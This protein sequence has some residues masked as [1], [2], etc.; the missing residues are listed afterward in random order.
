M[1]KAFLLTAAGCLAFALTALGAGGKKVPVKKTAT[2]SHLRQLIERLG[3]RQYRIRQAA[4]KELLKLD[5]DEAIAALQQ[6][7][8][9]SKDREVIRRLDLILPSLEKV[10][11]LR[12]KLVTL[13]MDKRTI[14]E[15][16]AEIS[17]QTGYSINVDNAFNNTKYTFKFDKVPFW[18]ALDEVCRQGKMSIYPYYYGNY[19]DQLRLYSYGTPPGPYINYSQAF[20]FVAGSFNYQ[21]NISFNGSAYTKQPNNLRSESLSFHFSINTEP[22]VPFLQVM[23]PVVTEAYDEKN[24]PMALKTVTSPKYYQPPYYGKYGGGSRSYF[25]STSVALKRPARDSKTA[26][27]IKG[28]IPVMLLSQQKPEIVIKKLVGMKQKNFKGRRSEID[29][30]QVTEANNW[31]NGK[32]YTIAMTVKEDGGTGN[33]DYYWS[34]TLQ[35]RLELVDAKGNKYVVWS[36]SLY[37]RGGRTATGSITFRPNGTTPYGPPVKLTF[38]RWVPI[39]YKI[40][41]EFKDLPLP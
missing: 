23:A 20:R 5:S 14:R 32:M 28:E 22:K 18:K 35:H 15:V 34:Q 2:S 33:Y 38:Y 31:G 21:R 36:S 26:K 3:D 7:Y 11:L 24:R 8:K 16:V 30:T 37:N 13:N 1:R 12:P 39:R 4:Q 27:L 17:R 40:K 41:F 19:N 29:I 6:A 25:H 9:T 10:A